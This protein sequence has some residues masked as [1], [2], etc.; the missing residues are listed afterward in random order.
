MAKKELRVG[1]IG[2][3][4]MGRTHSNAY[5]KIS[6]FFDIDYAVRKLGLRTDAPELIALVRRKLE[7][8]GNDPADVSP[9]RFK[10]LG[11]QVESQLKPVLQTRDFEAFDLERAFSIV[12][13]VDEALATEEAKDK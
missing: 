9:S 8:P 4:F 11:L 5:Q 10:A 13:D 12:A 1:V 2:Y 3:G 7:V 6:H